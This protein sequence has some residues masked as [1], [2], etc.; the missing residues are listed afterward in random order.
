M[1]RRCTVLLLAIAPLVASGCATVT[2]PFDRWWPGA[3]ASASKPA[4]TVDPFLVARNSSIELTAHA[5][6]TGATSTHTAQQAVQLE[7]REL[8]PVEVATGPVI[9]PETLPLAADAELAPTGVLDADRLVDEVLERNPSIEAMIATWQAAAAR[10]PQAIALD[11]PMFEYA[12][13]PD[14]FDD[15][16][17]KPAYMLMASQKVPW[18][19]KR[20]LRGRAANWKADAAA[21]N[22]DDTRRLLAAAA[23]FAFVDYFTATRN[24]ALNADNLRELGEFRDTATAKLRASTASQQDVLQSDVEIAL[25]EQRRYR[26]ERE[27]TV[28]TARINTLLDRS[29]DHP[30]APPPAE[31][32]TSLVI[33]TAAELNETATR[34]RPDLA[35]LASEIQA[36]QADVALAC[37]E[38]YPDADLYFKYDAFWQEPPL[39]PALGMSVNVP[40]YRD[41]R[42]A[43]VRETRQKLQSRR[44]EYDRLTDEVANEIEAATARF[45]ESQRTAQ[46]YRNQVIP[47][48]QRNVES[49]RAGYTAGGVDFLRLI[50]AERQLITLREQQ[51]EA[52]GDFHRALAELQQATGVSLDGPTNQLQSTTRQSCEA[53]FD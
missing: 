44:A 26:L 4:E 43:A 10:Y 15:P 46:L 11:D 20:R 24:L 37:K 5:E 52:V 29:A 17:L 39:R 23:R 8:P 32:G 7:I 18:P 41:K 2:S 49:A 53:F 31:L 35:A 21:N 1:A 38:F 3:T 34:E 13:G 51:V 12:I 9:S 22:I 42:W 19:G 50:D 45:I 27:A 48:A 47:A 40:I 30:L 14:S 16:V 28:A 6:P 25:L 36:A 33:P